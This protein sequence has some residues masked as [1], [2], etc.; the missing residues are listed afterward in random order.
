MRTLDAR[1]AKLEAATNPSGPLML[2][3][4]MD[5][6]SLATVAYGGKRYTQKP[7][8]GRHAFFARVAEAVPS[9][10]VVWVDELDEAL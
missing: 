5:A 1:V 8:E 6:D 4:Q 7:D 10:A 3:W 2:M 9:R